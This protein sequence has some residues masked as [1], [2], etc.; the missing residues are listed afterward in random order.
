MH[1]ES[2]IFQLFELGAVRFGEFVLKSGTTSPIY[3]DL[4]VAISNPRLLVAIGEALFGAVRG[5]MFDLLCGVPYAALP[6]ATAISIQHNIPLVLR[7]KEKKEY[8]TGKLIEGIFSHGQRCLIVEDVITS[9]KSILETA[10]SLIE[11]GLQVSDAVV[12]VDREQG[13][14]KILSQKGI[15]LQSICTI[16]FIVHLLR[17]KKKIDEKT[18]AAT[19]DFINAHQITG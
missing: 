10:E 1:V 9:G 14:G 8:G 7:R 13:G 5:Q 3:I 6:F 12:F 18:A 4:R 15:A 2:I 16:S 19:L 11:V 17:E